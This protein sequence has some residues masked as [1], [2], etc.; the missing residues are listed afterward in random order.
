MAVPA[1]PIGGRQSI[2]NSVKVATVDRTQQIKK[3]FFL[4]KKKLT[5]NEQK[6][7]EEKSNI[8]TVYYLAD[9]WNNP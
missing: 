7:K 5:D 1:K 6:K 4:L 9:F 2:E 3:H 8:H